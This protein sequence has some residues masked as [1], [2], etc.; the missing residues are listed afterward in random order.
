MLR[1]PIRLLLSLGLAIAALL[2]VSST[3]AAAPTPCADL[4]IVQMSVEPTLPIE[5]ISATVRIVI[6]NNG[7]CTTEG[8]VVQWK[9]DRNAPTGP[10]QPVTE[11]GPGATTT[12][13]FQFAFP[14]DGNF[15]TVVNVDTAN[16]VRET[17]EVNNLEILP[18]TV[19]PATVDL[20]I[21][22]GRGGGFKVEDIAEPGEN[23]VRGRPARATIVVKNLGNSPSDEF[24][25]EWRPAPLAAPLVKQINSLDAGASTTVTFDHTYIAQGDMQSTAR[26]DTTGRVREINELNNSKTITV[27]VEPPLPDLIITGVEVDPTQVVQGTPATAKVTVKNVGNN[28]AGA[29]R[30][31]WKPAPLAA[32]LSIQVNSLGVK[33][34]TTVSFNHTYLMPG[35]FKTVASVDTLRRVPEI[36]EDN[37]SF[38]LQVTVGPATIDLVITALSVTPPI[39]T[40]GEPATVNITV[41]NQGNTAADEF[42]VDWNPDTT[43]L[44]SPS[45]STL[46]KQVEGLG[47]GQSTVVSFVFSYQQFGNFR[48]LARVDAFNNIRETNEANNLDILNLSVAP[49]PI[50]LVI[51][52]FVIN[53][54]SPVRAVEASATIVVRNAGP[55][56]ANNFAV[57]WKL[58]DGDNFGPTAFVNG[59][60]PG[61]SRTLT[62]DG[63]YF[64]VG[65]FTSVAIVDVF[66]TVIEPG[67]REN[68]NTATRSVTVQ[69][70]R[71]TLEVKLKSVFVFNDLDNEVLGD[72]APAVFDFGVLNPRNRDQECTLNLP[73]KNQTIKGFACKNLD[74]DARTDDNSSRTFNEIINVTLEEFEPLV[75]FVSALDEDNLAID[76]YLGLAPFVSFPPAY[77]TVGEVTV[78]GRLGDSECS[79][80][81]CFTATFAIRVIDSNVPATSAAAQGTPTV[82]AGEVEALLAPIEEAIRAGSQ[83]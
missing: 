5:G 21:T 26:V 60:N 47:P 33:Q 53:P 30:V 54:A 12:V 40:Q 58:R 61:E 10:S 63:T 6:R 49:A 73:V 25:V 18:V 80:A 38:P 3:T 64:Q 41:K 28:P 82:A 74:P 39:P 36:N 8:F 81:R 51:T 17:N 71:A 2:A 56:P 15:L 42:L 46:S 83:P 35:A 32:P 31:E 65:T 29:F 20:V 45:P 19:V 78:D 16:T 11:L 75:T 4:S 1:A 76:E 68:N 48:T 55:F 7:T 77:R 62:L 72:T 57:Q 27:T 24:R 13:A 79:N 43:G 22:D 37:N 14:R 66:N 23:P 50:D 52:S 69:K 67:G 44:I 34:S 59:L 9:S 70:Q